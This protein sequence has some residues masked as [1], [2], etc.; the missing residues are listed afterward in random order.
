MFSLYIWV[1][2]YHVLIFIFF[3]ASPGNNGGD[4]LVAARHLVHFG[5][6]ATIV[7]PKRS[8]KTHFINLVKQ[9][10]D[11]GIPILDEI[12]N[13][14]CQQRYD[15]IVDAIFGFSFRGTAPREPFSSAISNMVELQKDEKKLLVSVDVP[16][17]W[18]V[19]GGDLTGTSFSPDVLISL[20]APKL[21]AKKF[22]GRHFVG[23]RFLPPAIAE[24]YN[25][26]VSAFGFILSVL[27]SWVYIS[28]YFIM[29][30]DARLYR[31]ISSDGIIKSCIYL[32]PFC[33]NCTTDKRCL[34]IRKFLK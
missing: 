20:T 9:C 28:N 33:V 7:Y 21:S 30:V 14:H 4:G 12:N 24:K 8:T 32:I 26:R 11:M 19:D 18:N 1:C 3:S 2:S 13:V 34:P 17:G 25:I 22:K 6:D 31:S 23:G 29:C 5:F 15:I 10:E 27:G 16:S